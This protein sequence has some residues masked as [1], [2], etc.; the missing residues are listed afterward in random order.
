MRF[1]MTEDQQ[2][3]TAAVRELLADQC[4]P[5]RVRTA[6]DAPAENALWTQLAQMGVVGMLAPEAAGGMGMGALDLHPLLIEAG[7]VAMTEP[8]VDTSA[9]AVP[10]LAAAGHDAVAGVAAGDQSVAVGF[11]GDPVVRTDTD[12][13]LLETDGGAWHLLPSSSVETADE[14]SVDGSRRLGRPTWSPSADTLVGE[15]LSADAGNRAIVGVA[16]QLL[17]LARHLLDETVAY[18]AVREQFGK[19]VGSQQAIKHKLADVL[20]AIEFAAP[21]VARAAYSID[22]ADADV[23]VHAAMAKAAA[24]DAAK[25]AVR[26]ALQCHGAIA[27]TVEYDLHMWMKRVWALDAQWGDAR[28]HRKTVRTHLNL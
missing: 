21:M 19:P 14:D 23:S 17:G 6:W 3:F 2:L 11:H 20:L 5:D 4:P 8:I 9:V 24:G 7:R 22:Q 10:L 25:L 27:Y 18:V 28:H 12:L 1:A 13:L 15:G 26:H 16:A